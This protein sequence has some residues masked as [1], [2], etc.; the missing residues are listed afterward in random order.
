MYWFRFDS[1]RRRLFSLVLA[2]TSLALLI[3]GVAMMLFELRDHRLRLFD[4]LTI[5]S[6]LLSLASA[7][8]LQ[9]GDDKLAKTT[10]AWL[11]VKPEIEA[12]VLYNAKGSRFASYQRPDV[13][14]ALPELPESDGHRSEDGSLLLFQRI[15][16]E[17]EILGTLYIRAEYPLYQHLMRYGLVALSLM[18]L[19]LLVSGLIS[20]QL[21]RRIARPIGD[22][23]R[24][25]QNV[26]QQQNYDLRA[27]N[28]HEQELQTLA[29]ALNGLLSEVGRRSEALEQT[30]ARLQQQIF[31]RE[32]ATLAL[33]DSEQRHR[34]LVTTLS[35]IVW[36]ASADGAFP[37]YQP[38]WDAYTGQTA[39]QHRYQGW[40]RAIHPDDRPLLSHALTTAKTAR[41]PL[42]CTVRLWHGDSACY[43]YVSLRAVPWCE[44]TELKEWIGIADD[45]DDQRRAVHEIQRLN[46]ELEQRVLERTAELERAN[47]ELEA[48]SYSVSHDLRT[49][50]RAIDGFSQALVEDYSQVLDATAADYLQRV[51]Q[52]AQRMG[53]LIDD[54]LKLARVSRSDLMIESV[55]LSE[56]A[57]QIVTEL[58]R[59]YPKLPMT[60]HITSGLQVQ[61]DA[62][63]LRI[64]LENLLGNAWKYCSKVEQ[65]RV[66]LGMREQ[67]GQACFFIED[68]GVGFDMAYADK[69]FGAFQRLHDAKDYPG[70]GVGLATVQRIVHRHGGRLWAQAEPGQGAVFYFTLPARTG[71]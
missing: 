18:G 37:E 31:E 58:Q 6:R 13:Q 19:A 20:W 23:V 52:A 12:A 55:N 39:S 71:V 42:R 51:R 68:N 57:G 17:Q 49:P 41:K 43:R 67:D 15:I 63:L 34:L 59:Q 50:L 33:K 22:L 10:L 64:V 5:Q 61:A 32:Q 69:L 26:V 36:T 60:A 66:E 4:D 14:Q 44:G 11:V 1:I 53:Q 27:G 48:F 38:E 3:F 54:L 46:A 65:P 16:F 62:R 29:G 2:S 25:A 28:Y 21:Q 30:N 47:N 70:T 24:L 40:L 56:L 45:I 9:F 8:A 7:P 35:S